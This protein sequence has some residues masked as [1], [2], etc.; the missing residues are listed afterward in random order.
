MKRTHVN[1]E[2]RAL[3]VH[4]QDVS[5]ENKKMLVSKTK[6]VKKKERKKKEKESEKELPNFK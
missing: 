4:R 2:R 1:Q 6:I 3:S 5:E